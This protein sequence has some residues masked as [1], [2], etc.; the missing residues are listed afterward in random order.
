MRILVPFLNYADTCMI[1]VVK[2]DFEAGR[3]LPT[4]L[5]SEVASQGGVESYISRNPCTP[6]TFCRRHD[7]PSMCDN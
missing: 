1:K 3:R 7:A 2:V 6:V 5:V 4:H